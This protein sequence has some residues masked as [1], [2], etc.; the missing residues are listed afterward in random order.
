[1]NVYVANR[2]YMSNSIN[3]SPHE[4]TSFSYSAI[5]GG[6]AQAVPEHPKRENIFCLST[7]LGD[8]YLF[9]V[10]MKWNNQLRH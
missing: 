8:A 6:I 1:M 3:K 4:A 2:Q 5:E 7:A 10:C 9:Q